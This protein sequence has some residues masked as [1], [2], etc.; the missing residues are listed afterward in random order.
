MDYVTCH[1][2]EQTL[3]PSIVYKDL[4]KFEKNTH[5]H[6]RGQ[7]IIQAIGEIGMELLKTMT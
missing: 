6:K 4:T 5:M 2:S 7:K 1:H 3:S